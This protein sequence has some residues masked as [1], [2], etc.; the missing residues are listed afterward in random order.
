MQYITTEQKTYIYI[1]CIYHMLSRSIASYRSALNTLLKT[2]PHA[3]ADTNVGLNP[4]TQ[5][6][7]FRRLIYIFKIYFYIHSC[8]VAAL[9]WSGSRPGGTGCKTGEFTLDGKPTYTWGEHET[10]HRNLFEFRIQDPPLFLKKYVLY[11]G[12]PFSH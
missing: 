7:C 11:I 12:L 9:S 8:S 5:E 1:C 4:V 10:L 6:S 3:C 2:Y